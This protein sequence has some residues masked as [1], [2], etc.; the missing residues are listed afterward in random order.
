MLA[1]LMIFSGSYAAFAA[2][3]CECESIGVVTLQKDISHTKDLEYVNN[4]TG[5]FDN[6]YIRVTP[7]PDNTIKVHYYN[8]YDDETPAL[9][10][11]FYYKASRYVFLVELDTPLNVGEC[12]I[13]ELGIAPHK[14]RDDF[15]PA[16]SHITTFDENF[17]PCE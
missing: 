12:A 7:L 17:S 8:Q 13:F 5:A 10:S 9:L 15:R 6:G 1:V 4:E 3:E 16:I 14:N 11:S 2:D